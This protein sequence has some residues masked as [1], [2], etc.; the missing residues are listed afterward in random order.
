MGQVTLAAGMAVVSPGAPDS[1]GDTWVAAI[2]PAACTLVSVDLV[3]VDLA[4][5]PAASRI[6][7]PSHSETSGRARFLT[8]DS[9]AI[10][11]G[12]VAATGFASMDFATTAMGSLAGDMAIRGRTVD[13]TI[14]P[15]GGIRDLRM[16]RTTS[17]SE[18]QPTR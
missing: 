8:T 12:A 9:E 3:S 10:I 6:L 15:G 1:A 17:G 5:G 13:I 18:P 11:S 7:V 4:A 2:S 14:L 16:T